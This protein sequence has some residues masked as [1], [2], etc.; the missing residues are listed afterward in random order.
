MYGGPFCVGR[1][2]LKRAGVVTTSNRETG[3]PPVHDFARP[4]PAEPGLSF[5]VTAPFPPPNARQSG[6]TPCPIGDAAP[7]VVPLLLLGGL[8]RRLLGGRGFGMVFGGFRL[9]LR[10]FDGSRG[11]SFGDGRFLGDGFWLLD[12]LRIRWRCG[13]CTRDR[14]HGLGAEGWSRRP[15][16][17]FR[18]GCA[19]RGGV[20]VR[21]VFLLRSSDELS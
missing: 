3:K 18:R 14:G 13:R 1:S 7:R 20:G 19:R 5:G 8:R 21:D 6:A 12:A 17:A 11:M 16:G 4:A 15:V 2:I 9:R 10:F